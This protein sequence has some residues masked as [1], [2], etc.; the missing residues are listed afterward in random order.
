M[1]GWLLRSF[2]AG[3]VAYFADC[4]FVGVASKINRQFL[5]PAKKANSAGILDRLGWVGPNNQELL[6]FSPLRALCQLL[7]IQNWSSYS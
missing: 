2:L 3:F 1:D 5:I 6:L 4:L 7:V